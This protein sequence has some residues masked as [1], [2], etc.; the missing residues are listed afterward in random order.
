MCKLCINFVIKI[1]SLCKPLD[2]KFDTTSCLAE[3]IVGFFF[4]FL[5]SFQFN[6]LP[7]RPSIGELLS[8][9]LIFPSLRSLTTLLLRTTLS[10]NLSP[11][12]MN[13]F[14][15]ES[16]PLAPIVRNHLA[17]LSLISKLWLYWLRILHPFYSSLV[18]W[19][20]PF[21]YSLI[22]WF[23]PKNTFSDV[24]YSLIFC[25]WLFMV[26]SIFPII[27]LFLSFITN[28]DWQPK[29]TRN[30]FANNSSGLKILI[31]R[32]CR[33]S[34]SSFDPIL[35]PYSIH[36]TQVSLSLFLLFL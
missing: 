31:S 4:L 26:S 20:Y 13:F 1:Y 9:I 35:S 24:M 7:N 8:D 19:V 32:S 33:M 30:S 12:K 14:Q 3:Q 17:Q 22:L 15:F 11:V 6:I 2:F 16:S 27:S 29:N 28:I 21:Y 23:Y 36:A 34:I 18:L 10:P 25:S 5:L